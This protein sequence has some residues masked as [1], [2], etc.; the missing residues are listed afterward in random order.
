MN[1]Y[2]RNTIKQGTDHYKI[3]IRIA[4]KEEIQ[5]NKQVVPYFFCQVHH[6][7]EGIKQPGRQHRKEP[8]ETLFI[9]QNDTR[10][11]CG[12]HSHR[13]AA[14]DCSVPGRDSVP[15]ALLPWVLQE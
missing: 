3:V 5:A 10:N 8:A 15:P 12:I 7:G 13:E 11:D 4:Q 9:F 1:D 6:M 2:L 14:N